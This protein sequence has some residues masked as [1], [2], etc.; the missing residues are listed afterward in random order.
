VAECEGCRK[1]ASCERISVSEKLRPLLIASE[2]LQARLII[3]EEL[4]ASSIFVFFGVSHYRCAT[5]LEE[6]GD[7]FEWG[8]HVGWFTVV[9]GGAAS[10]VFLCTCQ[11]DIAR[12]SKFRSLERFRTLDTVQQ[13]FDSEMALVC[14]EMVTGMVSELELEMASAMPPE[15]NLIWHFC[16]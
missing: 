6:C 13:G 2:D 7:R 15:S 9:H 8:H 5:A 16:F 1:E 3:S 11:L 4:Q 14:S 12:V 10:L